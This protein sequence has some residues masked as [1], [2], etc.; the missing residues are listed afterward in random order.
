MSEVS[1]DSYT[2]LLT[3]SEL[4]SPEQVDERL[5]LFRDSASSD[6]NGDSSERGDERSDDVQAFAEYLVREQIVTPWQNSHL[7][8]G[9]F[10]GLKFGKF[11]V[12]RLLG[13]G[14]MGRVFLAED[15]MLRRKVALKVLPKSK[16]RNKRSIQRFYQEARALA[17]LDH[18]NIVR[19]HDVDMRD[20]THYIVM[21]YVPGI[22]LS[23][24]VAASGPVSGEPAADWICQAAIGLD[25]AHASGLIHRDIKPGNL[26][27]DQS[28]TVKILDLGLALL[29]TED[30]ESITVDPTKTLGTVDYVSPEQALNSR[31]IDHRTDL[32]SLGCTLHF[33]LTGSAPFSNGTNAQRLLA[34]QTKPPP[35]INTARATKGLPAVDESLVAICRQMMEKKPDERIESAAQV[36]SLLSNAGSSSHINSSSRSS[37]SDALT[38]AT[39]RSA[40]ETRSVAS[41]G[42][43]ADR[44]TASSPSGSEPAA[45]VRIDTGHQR[46]TQAVSGRR[47]KDRS[48]HT[49][50]F[51]SIGVLVTAAGLGGLAHWASQTGLTD[52]SNS[53]RATP[54]D[55][56]T[57]SAATA[58]TDARPPAKSNETYYVVGDNVTYHRESCRHASGRDN[59]RAVS[60]SELAGLRPCGTCHPDN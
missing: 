57:S 32:Y 6:G 39:I 11:R 60:S 35:D 9:R 43:L 4:L 25:H 7:M 52:Q 53:R 50:L 26:L 34:H 5:R 10:K 18:P 17:K 13:A 31:G 37:Q 46:P 42:T 56:S 54:T 40:S 14:G 16:T 44:G 2:Q 59:L 30:D 3:R 24:Q 49:V 58:T 15:E 27:V 48:R 51:L 1:F 41:A 20:Q 33:L 19:V 29:Q 28:G 21:E 38:S 45:I 22:D 12:L 8:R 47:R 23:K 55:A 36:A